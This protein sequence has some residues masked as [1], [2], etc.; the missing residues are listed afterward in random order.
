MEGIGGKLS[1]HPNGKLPRK[2]FTNE[3]LE[4]PLHSHD[5]ASSD[6]HIFSHLKT[7]V[8]KFCVSEVLESWF[9]SNKKSRD[10]AYSF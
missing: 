9:D 8:R 6:Y 10:L 7:K 2:Q 1:L 5:L 4:H 3:L